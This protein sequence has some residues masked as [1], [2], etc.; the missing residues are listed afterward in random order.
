MNERDFLTLAV[1]L[2]AEST[3]AA[4]RTA[5]SRAYYAVFHVARLLLQDLGFAIPRADRAHAYL[6]LRLQNC[7]NPQVGQAGTDLEDLR[8]L[9]NRADYDLHYPLPQK[10]AAAQAVAAG[11]I[12]RSLDAARTQPTR[13]Q[14]TDAMRIYERD[15]LQDVTWQKP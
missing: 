14:I 8:R 12:L 13:T 3:E 2:A 1:S 4:W 5:V 11:P 10:V 15:V 9:R 7:G 6:T